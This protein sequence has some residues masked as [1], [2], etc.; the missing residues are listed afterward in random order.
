MI[1]KEST[2]SKADMMKHD[3]KIPRLSPWEGFRKIILYKIAKIGGNISKIPFSI[4][5]RLVLSYRYLKT[6]SYLGKMQFE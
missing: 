1:D 5:S 6:S 4:I 3:D 2:V